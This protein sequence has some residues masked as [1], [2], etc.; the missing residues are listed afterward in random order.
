MIAVSSPNE[1]AADGT[2]AR[3]R[4]REFVRTN[5]PDVGGDPELFAAR[6]AELQAVRDGAC[7]HSRP[8]A[9]RRAERGEA[10]I[11]VVRRRGPRG[12]LARLREWR[13][14]RKR[15]PRVV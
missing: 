5:H 6:V 2:D 8:T 10:P 3:A 4:L 9:P 15:G 13:A 7:G 11:V 12:L 14:R 1:R